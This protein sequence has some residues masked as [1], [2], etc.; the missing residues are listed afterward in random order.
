MAAAVIVSLLLMNTFVA[1][2]SKWI[3]VGPWW[4]WMLAGMALT[5]IL[6]LALWQFLHPPPFDMT[7]YRSSVDYEFLDPAYAEEFA[8]LNTLEEPD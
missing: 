3:A 1:P 6:P 4:K 8:L 7:A 5:L 2:L